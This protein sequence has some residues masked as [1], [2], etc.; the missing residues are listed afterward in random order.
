MFVG[1][2][3]PWASELPL[4]SAIACGA[5]VELVKT[6]TPEQLNAY[7][8]RAVDT[9]PGWKTPT[10]LSAEE[11]QSVIEEADAKDVLSKGAR[12][13]FWRAFAKNTASVSIEG[14]VV[15]FGP[16]LLAGGPAAADGDFQQVL[17]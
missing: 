5:L 1:F 8:W 6:I 4:Y 15:D 14:D 13:W 7:G 16:Q 10:L 2:E 3:K 17:A 12:P 9:E 11:F